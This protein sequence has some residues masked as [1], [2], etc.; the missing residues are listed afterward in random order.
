MSAKLMYMT[1]SQLLVV[2]GGW[3]CRADKARS[4]HFCSCS[5]SVSLVGPLS[6]SIS[7]SSIWGTATSSIGSLS[8]RHFSST[9]SMRRPSR[10]T[11]L[12][13]TAFLALNQKKS[14]I[15]FIL[16]IYTYMY[17]PKACQFF[18]FHYVYH[19]ISKELL[20]SN[21]LA[22]FEKDMD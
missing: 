12:S 13:I 4:L 19:C 8:S 10:A 2:A 15:T 6:G 11:W 16:P 7:G 20:K 3:S 14:F 22:V 21:P 9:S 18:S 5:F 1:M 17:V